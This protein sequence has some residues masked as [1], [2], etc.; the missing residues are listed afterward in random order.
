[1]RVAELVLFLFSDF[2]FSTLIVHIRKAMHRQ[3]F[4]TELPVEVFNIRNI[5]W[6]AASRVVQHDSDIIW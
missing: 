5:R 4:I 1:M 2:N 6:L 3:A